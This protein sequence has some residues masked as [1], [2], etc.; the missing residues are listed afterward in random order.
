METV[1]R[2]SNVVAEQV[3]ISV[4]LGDLNKKMFSVENIKQE[5]N[6]YLSIICKSHN[7]ALTF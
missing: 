1:M 3:D 7:Q 6:Y 5:S 4:W 2:K